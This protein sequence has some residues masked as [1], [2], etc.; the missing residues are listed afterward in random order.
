MEPALAAECLL[1]APHHREHAHWSML[2][3]C[4]GWKTSQPTYNENIL[5]AR[6]SLVS[7]SCICSSDEILLHVACLGV[8]D[9]A[10]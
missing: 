1:I 3:T 6:F 10:H 8:G 7:M 4:S 5:H 2:R 9:R